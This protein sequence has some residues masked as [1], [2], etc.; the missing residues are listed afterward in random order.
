M[1]LCILSPNTVYEKML[2]SLQKSNFFTPPLECKL[3]WN[4]KIRALK[5]SPNLSV[6][7]KPK[8]RCWKIVAPLQKNDF[9]LQKNV[10]LLEPKKRIAI[11]IFVLKSKATRKH[12]TERFAFWGKNAFKGRIRYQKVTK[13][14]RICYVNWLGHTFTSSGSNSSL[15][16]KI[17]ALSLKSA[18]LVP[19]FNKQTPTWQMISFGILNVCVS[20]LLSYINPFAIFNLL[21]TGSEIDSFQRHHMNLIF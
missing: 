1:F 16:S 6:Y 19:S 20:K 7:F 18:D 5:D 11:N 13:R 14:K 8:Y 2:T 3:R 17:E 21:V 12:C 4:D 9:V 15:G 10:L